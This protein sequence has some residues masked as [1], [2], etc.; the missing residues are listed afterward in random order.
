MLA[1]VSAL[2][3][4]IGLSACGDEK[5]SHDY[6]TD[7]K[8]D[9]T[10]H[11][12]ECKN[13]GCDEKEKDKAKHADNDSDGKCDA[14][15]YALIS[16]TEVTAAQWSQIAQSLT[17]YTLVA[18]DKDGNV[19][20]TLKIDGA[21]RWNNS[22]WV[23]QIYA[24]V[25]ENY[26]YY[27]YYTSESKWVKSSL[28]EKDYK[29]RS[30]GFLTY[31]GLFKDDYSK[32]TH[33]DGVYSAETFTKYGSTLSDMKVT[34]LN[35][36]LVGA[37]CDSTEDNETTHYELKDVGTTVVTLPTNCIVR[38]EKIELSES[39]LEMNVGDKKTLQATVLP[40]E[41]TDKT[42]YW[43]TSDPGVIEVNRE[44]GEITAVGKGTALV[45]ASMN[46]ADGAAC[47]VTV[48]V[49]FPIT[50]GQTVKVPVATPVAV[51]YE[52]YEGLKTEQGVWEIWAHIPQHPKADAEGYIKLG[53]EEVMPQGE[54]Q[55]KLVWNGEGVNAPVAFKLVGL[56]P[57]PVSNGQKFNV[58]VG[59]K[60]SDIYAA[61]TELTTDYGKWVLASEG[62]GG[63]VKLSDDYTF[64]EAGAFSY[65]L[66]FEGADVVIAPDPVNV[67]VEVANA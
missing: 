27:Q 60:V 30:D 3:C 54:L 31:P 41:A 59:E 43:G 64:N 33:S 56:S 1:A 8:Q 38:P 21:L 67:S 24:K 65:I 49:P 39:K 62:A 19:G 20:M 50:A 15:N 32:F 2:G 61:H 63:L 14:C 13:E 11:W 4:A 29:E 45:F 10:Y 22:A 42:V 57:C 51:F 55:A 16:E 53:E 28:T 47:E 18:S 9:E 7:W 46:Y 40:A 37:V 44:T 6:G 58:T 36:K 23:N 17:N 48:V 66:V 52:R 34:F 12:H 25:G 5:H 26:N 35:G